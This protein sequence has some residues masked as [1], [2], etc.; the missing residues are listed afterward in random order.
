MSWNEFVWCKN[1]EIKQHA[2]FF[3]RI[4]TATCCPYQS[5]NVSLFCL[6]STFKFALFSETAIV[7]TLKYI[8]TPWR[9]SHGS[10]HLYTTTSWRNK[11]LR[12]SEDDDN[13]LKTI[14]KKEKYFILWLLFFIIKFSRCLKFLESTSWLAIL[15][16]KIKELK[17]KSLKLF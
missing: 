15:F 12:P 14:L 16:N 11:I 5:H 6:F 13:L 1:I 17:V 9:M 3:V 7:K 2:D 10:S 4:S 8:K